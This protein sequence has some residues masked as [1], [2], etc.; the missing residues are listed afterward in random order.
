MSET[1]GIIDA[2]TGGTRALAEQGTVAPVPAHL[3]R[4]S[5]NK[6][7]E[8]EVKHTHPSI[9]DVV[10]Q[11]RTLKA[12]IGEA[13][14]DAQYE[15]TISGASTIV[16]NIHD[17]K[18]ELLRNK[19]AQEAS[20]IVVGT[21]V[22][23]L[24]KISKQGKGL[25]LTFE[26]EPVYWMR[27]YKKFRKA[28]RGRMTRAEFAEMLV[29]EVTQVRIRFYSPDKTVIQPVKLP[30]GMKRLPKSV[31][32]E[33]AKNNQRTRGPGVTPSEDITIK[34]LVADRE[35]IRLVNIALDEGEAQGAPR[36]VHIAAMEAGIEES[37]F[38]N[39]IGGLDDSAGTLQQR[40]SKGWGTYEQV[41]DPHRA[42]RI[43]YQ[44]AIAWYK[45]N[46]NSAAHEIAYNVQHNYDGASQGFRSYG[47]HIKEAEKIVEEYGS[48]PFGATGSS[49]TGKE[50]ETKPYAFT[51][52]KDGKREDTWAALGRL[53]DEVH[54]RR[55]VVG[56]TVYFV[57]DTTLL[58]Q[59]TWFELDEDSVGIESPIDFD[60]DIGKQAASATFSVRAGQWAIPP[61]SIVKLKNM[62]VAN[63]KWIVETIRGSMFHKLATVTLTR[64][65]PGL[66]EPAPDTRTKTSGAP[67]SFGPPSEAYGAKGIVDQAVRAAI[68]AGGNKVVVV[69]DYRPGSQVDG[70]GLSDHAF[71][72]ATRAARDIGVIG[73]DALVGPPPPQLDKAILALGE[74]FDRGYK[75]GTRGP[76]QNA[77]TFYWHGR[78]RIQII[79]RTPQWNGHMGHIHIGCRKA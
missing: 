26:T 53:A 69:S 47:S 54:W 24:V 46:P 28:Y 9:T 45:R 33:R 25:D 10:L 57:S 73:V 7:D 68:K 27:K 71:N 4:S 6:S 65:L 44:R 77:D 37:L 32:D 29:S 23:K 76:F 31:R 20:S 34:G 8:L 78:W 13:L 21:H 16:L 30:K 55:F 60:W 72:D 79:Y 17:P 58:K 39:L 50:I 56:L 64:P 62:G 40:P 70:G 61:G 2:V 49:E 51:R 35:Q 5:P 18:R 63:G 14:K 36:I 48:G 67:G 41:R 66:A 15:L 38:H 74:M 11:G 43:F 52:G 19:V 22:Y 75:N 12:A 1:S 59:R 42:F 3:S